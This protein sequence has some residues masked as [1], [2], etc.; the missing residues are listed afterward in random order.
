MKWL[1]WTKRRDR[2]RELNEEIESDFALEIQ[3]RL[4]AGAMREEAEIGA[5][6]HFGNVS[7]VKEVTRDMWSGASLERMG[8]D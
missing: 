4:E 7:Q 5:R 6:R 8:Q 2:D 3:E 1:P